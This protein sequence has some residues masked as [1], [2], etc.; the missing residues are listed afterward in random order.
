MFALLSAVA[1]VRTMLDAGAPEN[2]IHP[3]ENYISGEDNWDY[4]NKFVQPC[5]APTWSLA[6]T[7]EVSAFRHS[8]CM[9]Y[10]KYLK[11]YCIFKQ[12]IRVICMLCAVYGQSTCYYHT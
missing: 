3:N 10:F 2:Y 7:E 11:T 6:T 4:T 9:E 12:I 5:Y 8:F 1:A